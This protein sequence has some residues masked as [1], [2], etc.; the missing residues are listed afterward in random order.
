MKIKVGRVQF[1]KPVNVPHYNTFEGITWKDHRHELDMV[2]EDGVLI[3]RGMPERLKGR[4]VEVMVPESNIAGMM[5]LDAELEWSQ[6]DERRKSEAE[7]REASARAAVEEA[8]RE[9]QA[10]N[11]ARADAR[12]ESGSSDESIASEL[13]GKKKAKRGRRPKTR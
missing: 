13:G 7:A 5:S 4:M 2:F 3:V 1:V 9:R 8:E 10:R 12:L 6:E 11:K